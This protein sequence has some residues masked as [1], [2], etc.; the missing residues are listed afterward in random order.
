MSPIPIQTVNSDLPPLEIVGDPKRIIMWLQPWRWIDHEDWLEVQ[1]LAD[2]LKPGRLREILEDK[3]VNRS[4]ELKVFIRNYLRA[5]N[6]VGGKERE[7]T[8]R[9]EQAVRARSE[10]M[11]RG[12]TDIHLYVAHELGISRA[13][14]TQ[15]L[16]RADEKLEAKILHIADSTPYVLEVD[17]FTPAS[18]QVIK[19][20][21]KSHPRQ[22]AG[23]GRPST[24]KGSV[25][26]PACEGHVH[27]NYELC[28][29]CYKV[30]GNRGSNWE[31]WLEKQVNAISREHY[32][33]A[34]EAILRAGRLEIAAVFDDYDDTMAEAA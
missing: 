26:I 4:P 3:I 19:K 9:Q 11:L 21:M 1:A 18:R 12:R 17:G 2:E 22:C 23:S 8:R 6:F 28:Y 5:E 10:A 20:W 32:Q 25:I 16:M 15:L 24:R 34:V 30:Y 13:T 31:T 7:L 29:H 14:A 27:G 33:N